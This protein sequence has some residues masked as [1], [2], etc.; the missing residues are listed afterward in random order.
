MITSGTSPVLVNSNDTVCGWLLNFSAPKSYSMRSNDISGPA[1]C[2][3][4]QIEYS[5]SGIFFENAAVDIVVNNAIV[6]IMNFIV[7]MAIRFVRGALFFSLPPPRL[8]QPEDVGYCAGLQVVGLTRCEFGLSCGTQC[9]I[10]QT[11]VLGC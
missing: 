2:A 7:F 4:V 11:R 1:G 8:L 5:V 6:G 9:G 3:A 10:Y